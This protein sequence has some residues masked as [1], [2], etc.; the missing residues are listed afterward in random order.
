MES[1]TRDQCT[2]RAF[3][4]RARWDSAPLSGRGANRTHDHI[5]HTEPWERFQL[6]GIGSEGLEQARP[7]RRH[8]FGRARRRSSA[9]RAGCPRRPVTCAPASWRDQRTGRQVPGL[10]ARARSRGRDRP[11]RACTGPGRPIRRDE[12]HVP[13]ATVLPRSGPVTA[14][15]S[16]CIRSPCP[17]GESINGRAAFT[18]S[19]TPVERRAQP[20]PA[21]N[22]RPSSGAKTQP[23]STRPGRPGRAARRRRRPTPRTPAAR[24]GSSPCRRSG[25]RPT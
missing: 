21:V 10:Q 15:A 5:R 17:R 1:R 22:V 23:A 11:R 8:P 13:A 24:R 9:S 18:R 19:G 6:V 25:R 20:R 2:R 12:Y 14:P 3:C 4:S 7:A 16:P